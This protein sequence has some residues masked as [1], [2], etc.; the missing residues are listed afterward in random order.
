ANTKK[1]NALAADADGVYVLECLDG[2]NNLLRQFDHDGNYRKTIYPWNPDQLERIAISKRTL[3]DAKIHHEAAPPAGT[4]FVPMMTGYGS[5]MPF[6]T[7][8]DRT[9]MATAAGK[10]GI[11]TKGGFGDVRRL[12]RLRSDG[13]TGGEPLEGAIFSDKA[14]GA[15][16]YQGQA[17]MAMSPDGK[18]VYVTGLYRHAVEWRN[19]LLVGGYGETAPCRWNAVYRFAWDAKGPVIDGKDSFFGEVSREPK[20]AGADRDNDHL[21]GPQG[22]ACDAAGRLYIADFGNNRI[23]VLTPEGKYLKTIPVKEPQEIA[24]HPKTGEIYVL[25]F[26]KVEHGVPNMPITLYKFGPLSDPTERLKQT[27]PAQGEEYAGMIRVTPVMALDGW[28][29]EPRL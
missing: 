5:T 13:T 12:L 15:H 3:P 25:C 9:C 2:G 22:L 4:P 11:F 26:R 7:V 20:T 21:N 10:I 28:A 18:W 14:N 24:V 27:F 16:S 23:Q 8:V 6:H 17:H 1:I 29:A 19:G